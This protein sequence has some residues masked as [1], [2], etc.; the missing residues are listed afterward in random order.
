MVMVIFAAMGVALIS[1]SITSTFS[2]VWTGSSSRAYYLAESG[3]RYA[4]TE[5]KNAS[6][7]VISEEMVT[8]AQE[9]TVTRN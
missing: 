4:Q 1:M 2:Q 8:E 7:A 9:T 5:Y 6:D 3:F